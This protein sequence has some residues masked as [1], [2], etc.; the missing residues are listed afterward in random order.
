MGSE[1]IRQIIKDEDPLPEFTISGPEGEKELPVRER[2]KQVFKRLDLDT[3]EESKKELERVLEAHDLYTKKSRFTSTVH[4][5]DKKTDKTVF[6]DTGKVI[7]LRRTGITESG[8]KLALQ[9]AQ[10]RFGSTLTINGTAEFKSLVIEAA[11]K[12]NLDI[13]FTDRVM[14]ERL[15]ERRAELELERDSNKIASPDAPVLDTAER[16]ASTGQSSAEE[17]GRSDVT[18]GS[19]VDH[20]SA[21]Y[22]MDKKNDESYYVAVKTPSGVRTLWGVGLGELMKDGGYQQGQPIQITDKGSLPVLKMVLNKE[23]GV[24]ESKEV[25]RRVWEIDPEPVRDKASP[26]SA[27]VPV[28]PLADIEQKT[29]PSGAVPSPA[30]VPQASTAEAGVS[31]EKSQRLPGLANDAEVRRVNIVDQLDYVPTLVTA[32]NA[33]KSF[34]IARELTFREAM[35]GMTEAEIRSS[36]TVMEWRA[37][38]HAQWLVASGDNSTEGRE[39]LASYM[40]DDFY[41]ESFKETIDAIVSEPGLSDE[42]LVALEP[43]LEIAQRLVSVAE[44]TIEVPA[45]G[46]SVVVPLAKPDVT[47][48][49]KPAKAAKP[50]KSAKAGSVKPS[51]P[52]TTAGKK[53][54]GAGQKAP[55]AAEKQAPGVKVESPSVET[56]QIEEV[57]ELEIES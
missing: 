16:E 11:A 47:A 4:Y 52:K 44:S 51:A 30:V 9:M 37:A 50:A 8:V 40:S 24:R 5:L 53:S 57:H 15:A 12:N 29:T 3:D 27:T 18:K 43:A 23:T 45:S 55:V 21:P 46:A 26:G 28:V 1:N 20:G 38:D 17:V 54:A 25:F 14:N 49:A 41:R 34:I 36:S 19:L 22:M 31:A 10:Q 56:T 35:A 6:V 42:T 2:I 32:E 39:F 13:H 48:V 7:A 33:D